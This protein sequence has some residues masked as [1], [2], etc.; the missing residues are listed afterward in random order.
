MKWKNVERSS[1]I[2]LIKRAIDELFRVTQVT[3]SLLWGSKEKFVF[4]LPLGTTYY[5]N[6]SRIIRRILS[7][8][9]RIIWEAY[10]MRSQGRRILESFPMKRIIQEAY[11]MRSVLYK[12]RIIRDSLLYW[13]FFFLGSKCH[14]GRYWINFK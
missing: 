3:L 13:F 4:R 6:E 1:F 11:H 8:D 9:P 10:Y 12:K 14:L 7:E 2:K 5:N